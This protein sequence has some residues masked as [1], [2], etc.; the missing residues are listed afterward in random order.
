MVL[1][2]PGPEP[3]ERGRFGEF[4]GRFVPETLIPA[5]MD[6]EAAFRLAWSSDVF[7]DEFASLLTSYAGRPTPVTECHR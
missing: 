3:T 2:P 4:G 7:R 5:L 6:L 1:G